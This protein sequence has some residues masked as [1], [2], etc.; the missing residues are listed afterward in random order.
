M[1]QHIGKALQA[2][3]LAIKL[4][5]EYYNAA[6][7]TL[8]PPRCIILRHDVVESTF[9]SEFDLLRDTQ[10]VSCNNHGPLLLVI[11]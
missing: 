7:S 3:S 1:H 4:A 6:A 8:V 11:G 2:R 10:Q 9:L 5:L